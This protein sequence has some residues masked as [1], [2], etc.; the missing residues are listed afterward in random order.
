MQRVNATILFMK[1][2]HLKLYKCLTI[3]V[4]D[5]L[6]YVYMT[7]FMIDIKINVKCKND[8]F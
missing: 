6:W 2:S 1:V 7:E 5:K 4:D 8:C 3:E